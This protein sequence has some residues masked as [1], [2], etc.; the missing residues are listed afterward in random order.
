MTEKISDVELAKLFV[1]YKTLDD[2][3]QV[4]EQQ[5]KEQ[6][7][8]RKSSQKIAGVSAKFYNESQKVDYE[9]AADTVRDDDGFDDTVSNHT[10]T[11]RIVS[12][13]SVCDDL[14]I[15]LRNFT[16][17]VPACVVVKVTG[18]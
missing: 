2:Q 12:W 5:I 17:S 3:T 4:V 1:Q 13:K 18:E 11:K 16:S 14:H 10:E 8:L 9:K 15:D 7:L 6:V